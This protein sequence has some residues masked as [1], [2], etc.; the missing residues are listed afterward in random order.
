MKPVG[1]QTI[2]LATVLAFSTSR[3]FAQ[4][5]GAIIAAPYSTVVVTNTSASDGGLIFAG[6]GS[7]MVVQSVTPTSKSPT[8]CPPPTVTPQP[9]SPGLAVKILLQPPKADPK[10][11][12][13]ADPTKADTLVAGYLIGNPPFVTITVGGKESMIATSKLIS[14][15]IEADGKTASV[16]Y[17]ATKDG[18]AHVEGK[19]DEKIK[20]GIDDGTGRIV[21]SEVKDVKVVYFG[22]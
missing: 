3:C 1:F 4:G 10:K 22:K 13:K 19:L 6:P 16:L 7:T 5:N 15:S 17:S 21:I 9:P 2:L 12:A 20:F 18:D 8:P 11:E 14:I